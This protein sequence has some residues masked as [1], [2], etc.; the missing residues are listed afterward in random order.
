MDN[1]IIRKTLALLWMLI[2]AY[3]VYILL[4]G[5]NE[6]GGGFIGG[7]LL[8]L[9]IVIR[10]YITNSKNLEDVVVNLYP[11]LLGVLLLVFTCLLFLPTL[12]GHE[13]L[14]GQW[15]QLWVPIAGKFSSV[16]V[17]DLVVYCVVA[18]STIFA[19]RVLSTS[20]EGGE[21]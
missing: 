9:G 21:I 20:N 13:V 16:L 15:T 4:R 8:A 6:P 10:G 14:K 11:P 18:L 17:F 12:S 1:V 7:L 5:H 3:S 19:H 2:I